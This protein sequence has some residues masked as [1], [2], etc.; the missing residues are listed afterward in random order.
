MFGN[1][2]NLKY[3]NELNTN[4]VVFFDSM[5]I[6][7]PKLRKKPYLNLD[8]VL[9]NKKE[10]IYSGCDLLEKIEKHKKIKD[11]KIQKNKYKK[12][13]KFIKENFVKYKEDVLSL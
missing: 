8:N 3:I 4:K 13:E 9:D 12:K 2:L 1:C 10:Y 5:F 11:E 7:C 6:N